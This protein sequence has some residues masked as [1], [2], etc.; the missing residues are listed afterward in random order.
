[1][2]ARFLGS[3]MSGARGCPC[4]TSQKGQR[5]VHTSPRI[6][7]VAVPLAKHSAIFGQ[8]ASSQTV[9]NLLRLINFFKFNT[10]SLIGALTL[11]H[12]GFLYIFLSVAIN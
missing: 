5:L 1:M 7:K 3:L 11:I 4:A 9:C 6:I 2:F 12:F 10:S 8:A